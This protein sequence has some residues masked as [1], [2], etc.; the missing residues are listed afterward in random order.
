MPFMEDQHFYTQLPKSKGD[1]VEVLGSQHGF[2]WVPSDWHVVV[3]DIKNSTQS[4]AEGK[5]HQINLVATGA[6]VSVLN[7]LRKAKLGLE[8]PYFFGGDGATFL[9][10]SSLLHEVMQVLQNFSEHIKRNVKLVLR[11][12]SEPVGTKKLR[13][14]KHTLTKKLSI[15][16]VLGKGLKQAEDKIKSKFDEVAPLTYKPD[17]LNLEGMECRWKQINPVQ[18]QKKVICLLLEACEEDEQ[19]V[20]YRDVLRCINKLFGSFTSRQPIAHRNLELNLNP[21]KIW[22]EMKS[23]RARVSLYYWLTTWCTTLF[24]KWYLKMSEQGR[25]YVGQIGQLSHTFM[26]DGMINTIFTGNQTEINEMLEYL[27]GAEQKGDL[28]YGIHVTHAA[29]MSC[30]VIDRKENH[31][32]FVDGTEGGYTQAAKMLK[33]KRQS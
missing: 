17:L 18:S 19:A 21:I 7:T 31:T 23:K 6:I 4:V 28:R 24:G 9:I 15:P 22:R 25:Q 33:S 20:V 32:H 26:L 16:V 12:G 10:P 8:V 29:I 1:L 3:V 2:S 11:V 5:H 13:I 14:T 30:Y 27:N